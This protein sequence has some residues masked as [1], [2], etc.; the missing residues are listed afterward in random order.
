MVSLK[1]CFPLNSSQNINNAN[2]RLELKRST[3]ESRRSAKAGSRVEEG[4]SL[5]ERDGLHCI[6]QPNM[7]PEEQEGRGGGVGDSGNGGSIRGQNV[8]VMFKKC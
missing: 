7:R 8:P 5:C 2:E 1:C 4:A 3:P 6:H